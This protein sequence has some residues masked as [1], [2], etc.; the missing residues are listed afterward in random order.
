MQFFRNLVNSIFFKIFLGVVILSFALV[1]ISEFALKSPNSWVVKIGNT[2]IGQS[3]FLKAIKNDQEIVLASSKSEEALKYIESQQFKSDVLGRLVNKIM[4]DKLHKDLG[5]E[6]SRKLILANIAKD[7]N[8][9]NKEGKFD[10]ETFKKFLAKNGLDEE[11]YFS[12]TADDVKATMIL[13]TLS[14]ASPL[15]YQEVIERENFKQEKR[16]ADVATISVKNVENVSIPKE[17]ELQKFFEENKQSYNS[18]EMRQVSYVYFSTKDFDKDLRVSDEEI[19]SEYEKNKEFFLTPEYRDF[20]HILFEKE[21][22]AKDFLQKFDTKTSQDKTTAKVEFAKLAKDFQKKD[23]KSILISKITK[24]NFIPDLAEPTFKLGLNERS[25]VLSS[26]LGFHIFLTTEI[27]KPRPISLSEAKASLKNKLLLDREKKV[28]Q[29]KISEIDDALLTSKSLQEVAKKF[30]LKVSSKAIEIDSSGKNKEGKII[31]EIKEFPNF[32]K[33]AFDLK[34]GQTSK[35]FY[36][37]N[38]TEFYSI[39]VEEI[40]AARQKDFAEAKNQA[41]QDLIE[42]K[43]NQ[44]LQ[45]LAQKI[46]GEIKANPS[47]IAQIAAKYKIKLEKNREFSRFVYQDFQGQKIPYQSPFLDELFGLKIGQ[48]TSVLPSQSQEFII[49]FLSEIKKSSISSI[50]FEEAKKS[51]S[52]SF[53]TEIMQEYN[54]FLLKK[55]PVK[56]NENIMGKK[57]QKDEF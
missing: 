2:T 50:Q 52:E 18:P 49:A 5:V 57:E 41:L 16:L 24:Q 9:K 56:I 22:L 28:L 19:A 45:N 20:Y 13:Q 34:K 53:R 7:P 39:K 4:I 21:E 25:E 10:N 6:A 33:N 44:I 48:A 26:P 1:G 29:N 3:A 32:V 55:N 42:R 51:T 40:V 43:K 47:Q 36:A 27:T 12:E 15:N 11:R 30:G 37:K 54:K 46:G 38:P 14:M 8:F 23:L 17:E 31:D 35:I